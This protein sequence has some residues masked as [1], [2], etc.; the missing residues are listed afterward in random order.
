MRHFAVRLIVAIL[1][2]VG[3][4]MGMWRSGLLPV[5]PVAAVGTLAID[6]LVTT[7]QTSAAASITS[8]SFTTTQGGELVLAFLTSDG[9]ASGTQSFSNVTGGG[10]TWRL[11]QRTNAQ[12]GTSEIWQAV[13]RAE[14][15]NATITATRASGSYVGS[16]TVATF[17]GANTAI[18]GAT[19]GA[20]AAIGA[21][22]ASLTTTAPGSWVWG[23]GNDWD[24]ALART[25][26]SNQ[27]KVDEF[28]STQT[29]DTFWVQRQTATTPR[30]GT[31]VTINDTAPTSDQY[32]LAVIEIPAS[33]SAAPDLTVTKTHT[34][35]FVQGQTGTYTITVT[36]GGGAATSGTVTMK[37]RVPLGLTATAISGTGWTCTVA[38]A[39]CTR[40]DALAAGA[41]YPAITVKV[42]VAG[43]APASVTNVAT[44]SGGGE[45][46][47]A[48][49]M[50]S[51]VTSIIPSRPRGIKLIQSAVNG[52]ESGTSSISVSFTANNARGDFLI[53]T[54]SAAR[55]ASTLTISDTLGNR[56]VP[57]IGPVTDT[58]QNVTIYLWYVPVCKG[59]ANTVTITPSTTAALE[60]HV[61]EWS[62]LAAVSPVDR[63][64]S[65]TG[66]G[67]TVSSGP[68]ATTANGELVFG[69]GWVLNTA[70]A[71]AGFTPITRVNGDLT[72]YQIQSSAG[73][74]AATF[75]QTSGTWFA[76]MATFKP[77]G[78]GAAT[79]WLTVD[80]DPGRSGYA[81]DETTI[82]K[83]NVGH[84]QLSW[85]AAVHGSVTAQPLYVHGVQIAGQTRDVLVV[86]TGGNSIYAFDA[87]TGTVLWTRNFG[88][89]TPNTY[90]L[91]DGF[92]IEAS[93]VI[94]RVT[95]RIYTV[96]TDGAFRTISLLNG[97]DVYP[98][99]TL[100]A[101]P[102]TNKVWGGLNKVGDSVYVAVGSNGGDVAPWAGQVYQ[103]DVSAAPTLAGHFLVVPSIPNGGGGIWGSGGASADPA[104]GTIFA[105]SAFDSHVQSNGNEGYTPYADSMMA[106]TP[107]LK[108]LG[109]YQPPQPSTF[110]CG[111]APCDLDFASTPIFFQP[112]GCPT[113]VAAGNKNG[114]LYL[115][116][117]SDLEAR[118]H[119]WQILS[120]NNPYD[121]IGLGGVAGVPAYSPV[122]NMLYIGDAGKGVSGVAAG[123]VA[124]TFT[125]KCMMQV[126]WSNKLATA[127]DVPNSTPTIANGVVFIGEGLTGIIHAYDAQ[128]GVQLWQSG[129]QYGAAATF[130]APIVVGGS[131][132]AGSWR[133]F[134]GGGIVGAFSLS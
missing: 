16:L 106:L 66:T 18:A 121:S 134:S 26:G 21:P 48:N 31:M 19:A 43:N 42:N 115:F 69:Y 4:G 59:G 129:S 57:A 113:M 126:A 133:S 111:G 94:D 102:E 47:T 33:P 70:S 86:A 132:Y 24:H 91:P 3:S 13:A 54:G 60:M 72:E 98:G 39:T 83:S 100:V 51:D 80:H 20:H 44:V 71:G 74:V 75:T 7:H 23:A 131:V 2:V 118:G 22:S 29:G 73:S 110:P 65:A 64:A 78:V 53:V 128:T 117:V 92:G 104:T 41:T 27:T 38:T 81:S 95:K 17:I 49:D 50:A 84:L 10:L 122:T 89:P 40:G 37:D 55:P 45:T 96:S 30:A 99:L 52:N 97:A 114:N 14:L 109:Y 68:R 82:N 15:T 67:T 119:P 112:A 9:P 8:P 87:G 25:V 127:N 34:G 63:T 76:L 11:R 1:V 35:T 36:N 108:L 130:A 101:H 105:A 123:L 93:P 61:S 88:P 6:K 125:S 79:D 77:A 12:A 90:G 103:V 62:G 116:R 85:S 56:Y 107:R 58:T 32:N 124:L 28:L 5:P 120:L 46:N